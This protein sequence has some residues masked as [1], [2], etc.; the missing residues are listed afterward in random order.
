MRI[1]ILTGRTFSETDSDEARGVVLISASVARR[2]WPNTNPIGRQIHPHFPRQ[3]NFWDAQS[4]NLPL[5][6][7]GIVG[8]VREDGP[9]LGVRDAEMLYLPYRQNPAWLMHLVVRTRLNPLASTNTIRHAVWAVDHDQPVFDVKTMDDLMAET[10]SESRLVAALTTILAV[11]AIV[12]AAVG[13]YGML[14]Y[15]VTQRTAE[16]GMRVALGAEPRHILRTVVGEG[17]GLGLTGICVGLAGS[18]GATRLVANF[19]FGVRPNDPMTFVA[20]AVLLLGIALM[21]CLIPAR[22]AMLTDPI[23]ALRTE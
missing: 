17:T 8:D 7:I 11:L 23:V 3:R 20:V 16:I 15:L 6:V 14:S 22:R 9:N 4:S 2:L 21:A 12:L 18:L 1:P 5:T 19:A 13:L 10:F